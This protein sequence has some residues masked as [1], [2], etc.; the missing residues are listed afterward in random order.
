MISFSFIVSLQSYSGKS[1]WFMLR[2]WFL[3]G[4]GR[5]QQVFVKDLVDLELLYASYTLKA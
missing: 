3:P 4:V 5:G 2:Y 1:S